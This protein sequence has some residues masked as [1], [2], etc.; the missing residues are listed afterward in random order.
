MSSH[1]LL[2]SCPALLAAGSSKHLQRLTHGPTWNQDTRL[3]SDDPGNSN[4]NGVARYI[5][6]EISRGS[7]LHTPA[8]VRLKPVDPT[9]IQSLEKTANPGPVIGVR[10]DIGRR[11]STPRLVAKHFSRCWC[12]LNSQWPVDWA[13]LWLC[14]D[15][16]AGVLMQG[17]IV[18]EILALWAWSSTEPVSKIPSHM[19]AHI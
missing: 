13:L 16:S 17:P 6:S 2:S 10:Q 15:P 7:S 19:H 5:R 11:D 8:Y 4:E 3:T 14:N 12:Y 18:S 1:Q 9:S